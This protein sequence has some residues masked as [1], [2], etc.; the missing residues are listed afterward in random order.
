MTM[1]WLIPELFEPK[2][3]EVID[4]AVEI[5]N[6]QQIPMNPVATL[7]TVKL[8][9]MTSRRKARGIGTSPSASLPVLV[10]YIP[11]YDY[12]I[13][14]I[15]DNILLMVHVEVTKWR[16]FGNSFGLKRVVFRVDQNS[17]QLIQAD[18]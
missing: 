4:T 13:K 6:P 5:K 18:P 7:N 8:E 9:D 14:L 2:S 10:V 16:A 15:Y 3:S 11:G 17:K 1:L 12:S